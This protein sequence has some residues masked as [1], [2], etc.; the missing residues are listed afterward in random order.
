[1]SDV[2]RVSVPGDEP[3]LKALWKRCFHDSDEEIE[4]YFRTLYQPGD[5]VITEADDRLVSMAHLLY[6]GNF[7]D[8]GTAVPVSMIY[9]VGT[10]ESFRGRGMATR[11]VCAAVFQGFGMG[12]PVSVLCPA[13]EGLYDY[14]RDRAGF[15]DFFYEAVAALNAGEIPPAETSGRLLDG[16]GYGEARQ[17]LLEGRAHIRYHDRVLGYAHT[18]CTESG[19]GMAAL[20]LDDGTPVCAAVEYSGGTAAV[21]ELLTVPGREAQAAAAVAAFFPAEQYIF[22]TPVDR[23]HCFGTLQRRGMAVG[24]GSVTLRRSL[25][26]LPWYGFTFE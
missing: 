4:Q 6:P 23:A 20:E 7:Q 21:Q 5:A 12:A 11:E 3:A 8:G 1:M 25:E 18:L 15:S 24:D 16:A 2:I 19:G 13:E 9:A 22:H 14:Y 10:E 17:R 26:A